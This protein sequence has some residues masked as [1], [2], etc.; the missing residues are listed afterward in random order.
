MNDTVDRF[1]VMTSSAKMPSRCWGNYGN[2]AIVETNGARPRQIN[3]Q[4][5]S[6]KR[7]VKIWRRLHI[8]KNIR[9]EFKKQH[10]EAVEV[11]KK[12]NQLKEYI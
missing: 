3:P 8:G 7:I 5:K 4:H 12:L 9:S 1:I 2:V 11:C 6:V 10:D